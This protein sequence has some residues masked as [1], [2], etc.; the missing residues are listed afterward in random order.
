M[1]VPNSKKA[2]ENYR[3]TKHSFGDFSS[4]QDQRTTISQNLVL[5]FLPKYKDSEIF[6]NRDSR[7]RLPHFR[8]PNEKFSMWDVLKKSMGQDLSKVSM[9]VGLAEP[10]TTLQRTCEMLM[11][12]HD[13]L[14]TAANRTEDSAKR[15]ALCTVHSLTMY[16]DIRRRTRKTFNPM[17]GETYELVMDDFK[18]VSEQVSHHPPISAFHV[19]GERFVVT[20][21]VEQESKFSKSSPSGTMHVKPSA[22]SLQNYILEQYGDFITVSKPDIKIHNIIFGTMYADLCGTIE[23]KNH[24][25]GERATVKLIAKGAKSKIEGAVHDPQGKQIMKIQG[26]YLDK[27]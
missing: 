4:I 9:P 27:I 16:H 3:D 25:T 5:K 1:I 11:Q 10:L 8:D 15:L 22:C 13:I 18:F 19:E 7:S 20:G 12:E 21:Q 6:V 14:K 24:K 23:S 26:S 17:L 2:D